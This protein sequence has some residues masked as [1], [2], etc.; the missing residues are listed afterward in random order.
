MARKLAAATALVAF[1]VCVL[2]GM[3]Q[4]NTFATT[5]SRALVAMVITFVIGLIVG[6]MAEKMLVDNVRREEE[7]LK[8]LEAK[9]E[10]VDR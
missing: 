9:R 4:E 8:E 6:A 3:V 2:A 10:A 1:A 5:V 7:K